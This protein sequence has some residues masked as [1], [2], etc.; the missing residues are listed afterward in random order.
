MM[1]IMPFL[2]RVGANAGA[3]WKHEAQMLAR[4]SAHP[5]IVTLF[6]VIED[7]HYVYLVMEECEGA[8]TCF[9]AGLAAPRTAQRASHKVT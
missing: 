4:C 3:G 7:T 8:L 2:C 9:A 5:N 1:S 6:E